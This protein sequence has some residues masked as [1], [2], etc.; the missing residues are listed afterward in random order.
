MIVSDT[1]VRYADEAERSKFAHAMLYSM[2]PSRATNEKLS[3]DLKDIEIAKPPNIFNKIKDEII[4]DASRI[5]SIVIPSQSNEVYPREIA[6][7]MNLVWGICQ[8]LK[9][10]IQR[11]VRGV[12]SNKIKSK[13]VEFKLSGQSTYTPDQIGVITETVILPA[14]LDTVSNS[15]F[16]LK[17]KEL[18]ESDLRS[19][20]YIMLEYTQLGGPSYIPTYPIYMEGTI[21]V[22]LFAI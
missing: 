18:S 16:I 14:N 7:N 1:G 13:R 9:P 4:V 10:E 22:P 11:D 8:V 21:Q 3:G 20:T 12:S 2:I 19:S 6:M 15:H 5:I 17:V